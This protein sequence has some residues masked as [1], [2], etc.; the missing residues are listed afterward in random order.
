MYQAFYR[1]YR[2]AVFD[3]VY[4]QDNITRVLKH[5]VATGNISHAY[6]FHGSRGTGKTTCA[7]ILARAVN[8]DNPQNGDPCGVCSSCLAS[9]ENCPDIVEMD[10]ASNNGVDYIRDLR[11]VVNFSASVLKRRVYIIDEVHMLSGAAFNA[12]LKTLEEPPQGVVFILATTELQKIP[13]TI[14]SRCQRFD[15]HRIESRF[16]VER[17]K[18]IAKEEDISLEDDA[19]IT[20]ARLS[21]G[22]MRDAI[23]L[24]E[25]A[26]GNGDVVTEAL[27]NEIFGVFGREKCS[28]A[29]EA[30]LDKNLGKLFEIAAELFNKSFDSAS[31]CKDLIAYIRDVLVLKTVKDPMQFLDLT[32]TEIE[33]ISK[34]KKV[35]S[36]RLIYIIDVL[37]KA[38]FDLSRADFSSRVVL[39][40]SLL[41]AASPEEND[42]YSALNARV[43]SLEQRMKHDSMSITYVSSTIKKDDDKKNDA[44]QVSQP[45]I[46]EKAGESYTDFSEWIEISSK[47]NDRGLSAFAENAEAFVDNENKTVLLKTDSKPT[48]LMLSDDHAVNE[49]KLALTDYDRKYSD[50]T[51]IVREKNNSDNNDLINEL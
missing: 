4:G 1:K 35:E 21:Y 34:F 27:V 42:D 19:A 46:N 38:Y 2:P 29:L 47:I 9:V 18:Y 6:L 48:Y 5:E 33:D 24:L 16:I 26:A 23:S 11:E 45:R 43:S 12:L 31:F 41:R 30:I 49:I 17:L 50:Y 7:K 10:A 32:T 3:D 28:I 44:P 40:T 20:I 25:L 8:C 39:E 14:L 15:F 36:N 13:S 37:Q 22:G 51:V